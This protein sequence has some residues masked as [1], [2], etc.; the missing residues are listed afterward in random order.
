MPWLA[1]LSREPF[2]VIFKKHVRKLLGTS[3]H[4][5]ASRAPQ[6]V[7][8]IIDASIMYGAARWYNS[9]HDDPNWTYASQYKAGEDKLLFIEFLHDL[10]LYERILLDCSSMEQAGREIEKL[11][12]IVNHRLRK[13][14]IQFDSIAPEFTISAVAD[15]V[16]RL[17]A[18]ITHDDRSYQLL[19]STRVPWY[20]HDQSH[21]DRREFNRAAADWELDSKLIPVAIFMYRGFAIRATAITTPVKGIFPRRT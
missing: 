11:R 7:I 6:R 9:V 3:R 14:L 18:D 10:L 4:P 20:Y 2:A 13:N 16:C 19:L 12:D 15:L 1:G 8:A 21:H 5:N 17:L